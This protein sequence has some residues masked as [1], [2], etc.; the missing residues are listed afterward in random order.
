MTIDGQWSSCY[1]GREQ[2]MAALGSNGRAGSSGVLFLAQRLDLESE[3]SAFVIN[4]IK[5]LTTAGFQ[6]VCILRLADLMLH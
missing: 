1:T 5:E 3:Y 2:T 6:D 4:N